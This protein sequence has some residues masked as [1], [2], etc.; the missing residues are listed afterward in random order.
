MKANSLLAVLSAAMITTGC[1]LTPNVTIVDDLADEETRRMVS[2]S[3]WV[4][5]A[6]DAR[7]FDDPAWPAPVQIVSPIRSTGIK[8]TNYDVSLFGSEPSGAKIDVLYVINGSKKNCKAMTT[9]FGITAAESAFI[10]VSDTGKEELYRCG[11]VIFAL[12]PNKKIVVN[13][14]VNQY[15]EVSFLSKDEIQELDKDANLKKLDRAVEG[16]YPVYIRYIK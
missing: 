16:K 10:R 7:R 5:D 4:V 11:S 15:R 14:L 9:Y 1:S 8:R 3:V 2:D 13:P 12:N 6:K